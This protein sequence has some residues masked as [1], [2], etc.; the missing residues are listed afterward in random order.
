ML[1][2]DETGRGVEASDLGVVRLSENDLPDLA[3]MG[4]MSYASAFDPVN[5]ADAALRNKSLRPKAYFLQPYPAKPVTVAARSSSM[6]TALR[7]WTSVR[8]LVCLRNTV[9]YCE[10]KR[11]LHSMEAR[12]KG[13]FY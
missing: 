8:T 10:E 12:E 2:C 5:T 11:Q 4:V 6:G 1:F 13:G 9:L 7:P 3:D